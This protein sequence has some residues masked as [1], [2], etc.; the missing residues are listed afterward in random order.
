[1]DNIKVCCTC[2][3]AV[4]ACIFRFQMDLCLYVPTSCVVVQISTKDDLRNAR[5]REK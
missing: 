5:E 3:S 1:M 4:L 2:L